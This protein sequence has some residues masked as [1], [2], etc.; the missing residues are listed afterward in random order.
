MVECVVDN[1]P[2]RAA[3]VENVQISVL[4]TGTTEVGGRECASMKGGCIDR[5]VFASS[6]LVDDPIIS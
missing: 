2:A 5:L 1:H 3:G 4:D 6:P